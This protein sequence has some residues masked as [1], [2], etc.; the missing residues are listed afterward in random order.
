MP[1]RTRKTIPH[2]TKL[3]V[4]FTAAER[5]LIREHTFYDPDFGNFAV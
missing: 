1:R 2:G 4:H 3:P 5:D